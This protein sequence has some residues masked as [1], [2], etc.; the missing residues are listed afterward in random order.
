[1]ALLP[2]LVRPSVLVRRQALYRG[3]F[4]NSWLWRTVAAVV[5][6]R[7]LLKRLFGRSP[8]HIGTVELRPERAMMIQTITPTSR[9]QR[10]RAK[11]EGR[12]ITAAERRREAKALAMALSKADD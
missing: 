1:M 7:T 4:G 3:V 10:R 8:E 6:G 5:F 9:R 12:L 2:S 11:R